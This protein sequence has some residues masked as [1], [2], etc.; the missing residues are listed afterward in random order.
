MNQEIL[1]IRCSSSAHAEGPSHGGLPSWCPLGRS[2]QT[3]GGNCIFNHY[4]GLQQTPSV[5]Q[6]LKYLLS[7]HLQKKSTDLS[8]TVY[9]LKNFFW[10]IHTVEYYS[11]MQINELQPH[12]PLLIN[13]THNE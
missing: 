13:L 7:G 8:S 9:S 3:S 4:V 2:S 5:P 6:S 11:A 10:R 1:T 12:T